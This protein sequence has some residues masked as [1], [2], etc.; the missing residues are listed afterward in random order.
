[1]VSDLLSKLKSVSWYCCL[2][3]TVDSPSWLTVLMSACVG[4]RDIHVTF[5]AVETVLRLLELYHEAPSTEQQLLPRLGERS[6]TTASLLSLLTDEDISYI[7]TK[8]TF[9]QVSS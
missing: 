9:V 8:T 4:C 6:A 7:A 2:A 3:E 1:M 5:V